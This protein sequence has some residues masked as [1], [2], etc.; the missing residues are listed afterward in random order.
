MARVSKRMPRGAQVGHVVAS[1][2]SPEVSL[3]YSVFAKEVS[4]TVKTGYPLFLTRFQ[5]LSA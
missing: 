5:G 4:K 3:V 2:G 1:R